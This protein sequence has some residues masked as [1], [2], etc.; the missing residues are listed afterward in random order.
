[1]QITK[2]GVAM[3]CISTDILGELPVTAKGHK[4]ILVVSDYF[5]KW[6]ECFSMRNMEAETVAQLIVKQMIVRF[7][8]PYLIH[9]DQGTQYES[10]LFKETS[11]LLGI[12]KTRTTPYY[13]KS[14][15][16]VERLNK[17][18]GIMLRVYID[19]HQRDW[20]KHLP[21]LMMVA[22]HESTGCAP[23]SL[24]LGR[25]VAKPLD[26]IYDIPSSISATPH[27]QWAWGHVDGEM[28]RQKRYHDTKRK[29]QKFASGDKVYVFFPQRKIGHSSKLTNYWRGPFDLLRKVSDLLYEINFG[30]RGKPQVIHVDRLRLQSPQ[31]LN[32]EGEEEHDYLPEKLVDFSFKSDTGEYRECSEERVSGHES[33]EDDVTLN[34][35]VKTKRQHHAPCRHEDYVRF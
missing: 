4:Y 23:N 17:T 32:G 29:W 14:D 8:V 6:T 21:Y 15:G 26:I 11:K 27:H 34:N 20:D 35:N 18:L 28:R 2:A 12:K 33:F 9:S 13:P 5:S 10:L 19:E 31:I 25:E 24:M 30:R 3:E 1:M 7:G 22:E 16:M